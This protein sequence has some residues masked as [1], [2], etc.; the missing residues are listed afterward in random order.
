MFFFLI[1]V[2]V[3]FVFRWVHTVFCVWS[4][5]NSVC[6]CVHISIHVCLYVC[7]FVNVCMCVCARE[8]EHSV[9]ADCPRLGLKLSWE[10]NRQR[11]QHSD[12]H[13]FV[14]IKYFH[15][16]TISVGLSITQ[17]FDYSHF[18]SFRMNSKLRCQHTAIL[19]N[20]ERKMVSTAKTLSSKGPC[21][22][23]T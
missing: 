23:D 17:V 20:S 21:I 10:W 12:I 3:Y 15:Q 18:L 1:V 8:R 2:L 6:M 11:N 9:C 7:I 19:Y 14:S 4:F 13:N 5:Y 16:I 22:F